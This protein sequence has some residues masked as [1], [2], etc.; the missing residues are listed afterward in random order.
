[1]SRTHINPLL[2]QN[3]VSSL[4][5]TT[6]YLVKYHCIGSVLFLNFGSPMMYEKFDNALARALSSED[7]SF[8]I[9]ERGLLIATARRAAADNRIKA[10]NEAAL[11]QF[12]FAKIHETASLRYHEDAE[13]LARNGLPTHQTVAHYFSI[14]EAYR[15]DDRERGSANENW[16][17]D[18]A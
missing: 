7:T 2:S 17:R 5:D 12:H 4:F 6:R 3:I 18:V 9:Q 14:A 8:G 11:G 13:A 15:S 10:L 1:M 16:R